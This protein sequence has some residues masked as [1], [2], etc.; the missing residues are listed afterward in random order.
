MGTALIEKNSDVSLKLMCMFEIV[1]SHSILIFE[2]CDLVVD[3]DG[4]ETLTL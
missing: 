2:M 3:T 1:H 4:L